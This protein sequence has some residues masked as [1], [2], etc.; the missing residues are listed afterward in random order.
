LDERFSWCLSRRLRKRETPEL[1][2]VGARTHAGLPDGRGVVTKSQDHASRGTQGGRGEQRGGRRRADDGGDYQLASTAGVGQAIAHG[3]FVGG[4]SVGRATRQRGELLG[5]RV[6]VSFPPRPW[7]SRSSL[8]LMR[9]WWRSRCRPVRALI[10]RR[11]NPGSR[12]K[13]SQD[14]DMEKCWRA[15]CSHTQ[16]FVAHRIPAR[17][18]SP[19][20]SQHNGSAR[21]VSA[22][23]R[24]AGQRR[25]T[26]H[27]RCPPAVSPQCRVRRRARRRVRVLSPG[28]PGARRPRQELRPHSAEQTAQTGQ[29]GAAAQQVRKERPMLAAGAPADATPDTSTARPNTTAA[30]SIPT[31]RRQSRT[32]R[33]GSSS[34]APSACP[35]SS[36]PT[37]AP[38]PR[39]SSPSPT[40]TI[41]PAT[42]R[43]RTSSACENG[44]ASRPTTRT[45]RCEGPAARV[46]S[47]GSSTSR[48]PSATSPE[49]QK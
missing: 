43:P 16:C 4:C 46:R 5:V 37:R 34:P 10:G 31:S 19:V 45:A 26:R 44:R 3:V 1:F 28:P 15:A 8:T 13:S 7:F 33:R 41:R 39:T 25:E 9:W 14:V 20:T 22:D 12:A 49:S 27:P 21:A 32:P 6:R 18:R 35:A 29:E 47:S 36:R 40:S 17:R 30:L 24:D 11:G 2:M 23:R 48:A 42:A 38:S